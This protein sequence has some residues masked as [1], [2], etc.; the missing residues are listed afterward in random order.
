MTRWRLVVAASAERRLNVLP[1][2]VASA[3]VEF[4]LG[5][6][7]DEPH[8]VGKPLLRELS[9]YPAA[10]RGVYR[11]IY[12]INDEARTIEVVR[13]DHRSRVYRSH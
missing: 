6:L 7:I 2:K 4:M 13:I 12:R 10:R 11:I 9:G 5:P 3:I 1:P 8:R